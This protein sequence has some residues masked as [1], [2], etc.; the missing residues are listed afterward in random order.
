MNSILLIVVYKI[1]LKKI[2]FS[3]YGALI[4]LIFILYKYHCC[5]LGI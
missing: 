2:V 5:L 3:K 4:S 1:Y